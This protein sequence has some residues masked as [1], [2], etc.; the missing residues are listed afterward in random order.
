M[1]LRIRLARSA[2]RRSTEFTGRGLSFGRTGWRFPSRSCVAERTAI[3]ALCRVN[4]QPNQPTDDDLDP[5]LDPIS[6]IMHAVIP[7][8]PRA[9]A[10]VSVALAVFPMTCRA[11]HTASARASPLFRSS[12]FTGRCGASGPACW[13][14]RC[15]QCRH[16]SVTLTEGFRLRWPR[17]YLRDLCLA[18]VLG[19]AGKHRGNNSPTLKSGRLRPATRCRTGFCGSRELFH[20]LSTPARGQEAGVPG[21]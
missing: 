11:M 5:I 7:G 15:P 2:L 10:H 13:G 6:P 8:Q 14:S 12:E 19:P 1:V 3:S 16:N 21:L 9:V 18:G 20:G 4:C 17:I